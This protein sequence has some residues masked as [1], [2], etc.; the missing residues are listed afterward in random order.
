MAQVYLRESREE[1]EAF[2][3]SAK[4]A[5]VEALVLTIDRP[6]IGRRDA[7]LRSEITLPGRVPHD[8][9]GNIMTSGSPV[10]SAVTWADIEWLRAAAAP[11]PLVVKGVLDADDALR[12][13]AAGCAA[14]WVSNHGGRQLDGV[15][16]TAEALPS[17]AR[18]LKSAATEREKERLRSRGGGSGIVP[19]QRTECWVD[20]GVRRGG[21]VVKL[22]ALGADFVWIGAPIVWGLAVGGEAGVAKVLSIFADEMTNAIAL[23]GVN[24]PSEIKPAHVAWARSDSFLY[25]RS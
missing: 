10:S 1:N 20:G 7:L 19:Q 25:G 12:A 11:L 17:I 3:A 21:D 9:G 24:E 4:R 2:I 15:A 8:A 23:L 22:L 16:S 18:A 5:G 14:V 13:A 6:Y